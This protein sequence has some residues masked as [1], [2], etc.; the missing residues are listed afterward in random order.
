MTINPTNAPRP[1]PSPATGT[2]RKPQA[3]K[4]T[5][6][7]QARAITTR[8]SI[9]HAAI[10]EF[11]QHGFEG[12]R[13][14]RISKASHTHDRMI[15]YY[16][17]NKENLFAEVL[18][19][20]Y[21]RMNVAETELKVDTDDPV[22]A[23]TAVIHFTWQYYLDH[24]EFITLL[25]TENLHQGMHLQKTDKID[26]LL[27]PG[28]G[29][30]DRTLSSGVKKGIFRP[31]VEPRDLYIA[32]AALGYFY[33]SNRYTLSAFLSESLMNKEALKHWRQFI[34]ETILRSI[35]AD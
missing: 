11:S 7:T 32:I 35:T 10:E 20:I 3:R 6:G 29:I 2:P 14:E 28:V 8:S 12:G 27:P 25:N 24:P 15:Y 4:K 1:A 18:K 5:P 30:L 26:E 33:L 21:L 16:F 31:G 13:I 17:G 22:G 19:T 9:L 23:L 34:T